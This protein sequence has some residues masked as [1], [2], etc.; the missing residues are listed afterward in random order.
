MSLCARTCAAIRRYYTSLSEEYDDLFST[1]CEENGLDDEADLR[2]EIQNDPADCL[3]VDFDD[4]FPFKQQPTDEHSRQRYIHNIIRKCMD[5]PNI[6]FQ[7]IIN[8]S[9]INT[10]D[11]KTV[12]AEL[13]E[14]QESGYSLDTIRETYKKQC[15]A[16]Y[17][18]AWEIDECFLTMLA[19]G[20]KYKFDYLLHLVDDFN[21]W[22]ILNQGLDKADSTEE[23][24]A[25]HRH[26]QQLSK[27]TTSVANQS[28]NY[29]E[30]ATRAVD[31]FSKRVCPKLQLRPMCKID[32]ELDIIVD[33]FAAAV[34]WISRLIRQ[35]NRAKEIICP[36]QVDVC[37]VVGAPVSEDAKEELKAELTDND[38][39]DD[40]PEVDE[41]SQMGQWED[42][43]GNIEERV[44]TNKLKYYTEEL[45]RDARKGVMEGRLLQAIY[46]NFVS[47]HQL[48]GD[49]K[50]AYLHQKRLI[51]MVDRRQSKRYMKP[52]RIWMYEPPSGLNCQNIPNDTVPEWYINSSATCL[53]PGT[54][55]ESSFG[56]TS[57]CKRGTLTFSFHVKEQ[58]CI[59]CYLFWSGAMI[60]FMPEDIKSVLPHLFNPKKHHHPKLGH[61]EA[62]ALDQLIQEMKT[63]LVDQEFDAFVASYSDMRVGTAVTILSSSQ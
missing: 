19:V 25:E 55:T 63:K 29:K 17:T 30:L 48:R 57:H 23:W 35:A 4:D 54:D 8:R 42:I 33:Y 14:L 56:G 43:V 27:I 24:A 60:R 32:D 53:A 44:Q 22:R 7:Y 36:F 20:R 47:E 2:D 10:P 13:F 15:G 16:L 49:G 21:R 37:I 5:N 41:K 11:F 61:H 52:D 50:S 6:T 18:N 51:A 9:R 40:D 34:S 62:I 59:K 31:S 3:L 38:E 26:F 58:T 1:Y 39:E 46:D 45:I 12:D 28:V